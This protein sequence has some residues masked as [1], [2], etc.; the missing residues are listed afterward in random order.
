MDAK[1]ELFPEFNP[2]STQAWLDKI[3]QDLKDCPFESW[4][5]KAAR[6]SK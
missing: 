6:A 5:G 4:C 3:Q 2:V 1:E